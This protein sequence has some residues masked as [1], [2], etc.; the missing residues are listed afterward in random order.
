MFLLRV[1]TDAATAQPGIYRGAISIR[2]EAAE[3]QLPVEVEVL[4]IVLRTM[5]EAGL[6]ASMCADAL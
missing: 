2:G 1:T 3:A 6:H 5:A 4:P